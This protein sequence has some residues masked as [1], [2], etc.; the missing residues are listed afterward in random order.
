MWTQYFFILS[1]LQNFISIVNQVI[2]IFFFQFWENEI[3]S[4]MYMLIWTDFFIN[5]FS[6]IIVTTLWK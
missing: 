5:I 1:F 2:D 6:T 4:Q 3:A